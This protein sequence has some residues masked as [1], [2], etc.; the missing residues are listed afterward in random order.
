MA[1]TTEPASML[2]PEPC[3]RAAEVSFG[4]ASLRVVH[5]A[6]LQV[7][8]GE[9]VVL[10]GPN[11]AGKSTLVKGIIGQLPL[12]SGTLD[13]NG[14]DISRTPAQIRVRQGLGYVPQIRDVFPTLSVWENLTMGG[15]L[16]ARSGIKERAEQVIGDFPALDRLRRRRAGTLSGGERKM[17]AIARALMAK[18]SV[19]ILDEP[20]SNLAPLIAAKVLE[21]IVASLAGAGQAVLMIEQRVELALQVATYGYVLVQGQMRLDGHAAQ[22]QETEDLSSLFFSGGAAPLHGGPEAA[23]RGLA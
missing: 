15:Y 22:L 18:P 1:T 19:L 6:S 3:L 23:T 5:E 4:Y 2:R 9:T 21:E 10:L 13:L 17:L 11:G 12:L 16:L 7:G 8:P 14:S 20:T